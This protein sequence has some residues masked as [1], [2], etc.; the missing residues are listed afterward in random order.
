LYTRVQLARQQHVA[1]YL[2]D[3]LHSSTPCATRWSPTPPAA[4]TA[5]S[6]RRAARARVRVRRS[7]PVV[8]RASAH[9]HVAAGI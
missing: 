2:H 6:A 7:S 4:P 5:P 3:S 9:T 8:V 1:P